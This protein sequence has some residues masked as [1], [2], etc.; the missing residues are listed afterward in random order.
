MAKKQEDTEHG[1]LIEALTVEKTIQ[2]A[3][4]PPYGGYVAC[5][6]YRN[7]GYSWTVAGNDII[8]LNK[9]GKSHRIYGPSYISKIYD[10]EIW[11]KDGIWHRNDGGPAIRHKGDKLWY[12]EGKLHRLDGPAVISGGGP[13]QFWINGQK[14]SPKEYKKEIARRKRKG[15]LCE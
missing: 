1:K 5:L 4:S 11:S 10:V 3:S 14:L 7:L 2:Q 6:R 13:K 8:Y 15:I 12:V 9:Q